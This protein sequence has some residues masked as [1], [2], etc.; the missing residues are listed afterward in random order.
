MANKRSKQSAHKLNLRN[1]S[2][3]DYDDIKEIMDMVYSNAGG[4]WKK[5]EFK[6]QLKNFPEGQICIEDN[7]KVVAAAF[8]LIVNYADYGDNHTYKQ[9]TGDGMLDNHDID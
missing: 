2:E 1:I 9:I 7:G 5:K 8:S 3:D 4:A 6:S